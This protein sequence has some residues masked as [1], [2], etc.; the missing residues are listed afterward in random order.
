MTSVMRRP[1]SE[2]RWRC[3]DRSMALSRIRVAGGAVVLATA[4]A[5]CST[6]DDGTTPPRPEPTTRTSEPA[7]TPT[8]PPLV[9]P[10]DEWD[11]APRGDWARFDADLAADATSCVAVVEN[12]RLVHEAY[13]NGG[14]ADVPVRTYSIT[15]SLTSILVSMGVAD[16]ALALD[17]PAAEQVDEW[18]VG[19]ASDVTVRDLLAQVSGREWSEA[20]DRRLIRGVADQT[21]YAVGLRQV[22][23]PGEWVY[24]NAA[25]QVLERVLAESMTED[26]DVVALARVRLLDPLGMDAT[27]WPRDAAGHATTYSGVTS[28]CRDLARVGHLMLADGRWRDDE[29][30]PADLVAE[31]TQPATEANAAYGQLWWTNGA[32]RVVEARR[33][34]GFAQ[35]LAPYEGRLAPNV[36]ADAFWAFGY[37]NQ[38]VAVVPSR[39]L[40]A[41]RL[42]RL[43]AGPERVTFDTF[44]A[45][46][47]E[48]LDGP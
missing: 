34:A 19:P 32:G 41:V 7:P 38:Y 20:T 48:V 8:E 1:M 9:F 10:G 39:D 4:V 11:A 21:A 35:D 17:D 30:V 18:R 27:T 16:G 15:K 3:H 28:T 5:A 12:G 29:L 40:V 46:V 31:A 44:T 42:G 13:F 25:P 6:P 22:A 45:G 26:G 36:P 37:G 24:D 47:L 43:P 2:R 33:Q 23:P 14:G